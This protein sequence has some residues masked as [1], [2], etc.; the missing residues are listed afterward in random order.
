MNR[1]D[2]MDMDLD[3]MHDDVRVDEKI[4][5]FVEGLGFITVLEILQGL[6]I[7]ESRKGYEIPEDIDLE[8]ELLYGV[9]QALDA[10]TVL[11]FSEKLKR[12]NER[13]N[14]KLSGIGCR[15]RRHSEGLEILE[16]KL[17]L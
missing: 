14:G 9:T 17:S 13:I 11:L 10:Y 2:E 4:L 8:L 16:L 1:F 5:G 3:A 6:V 15:V 12:F 7:R